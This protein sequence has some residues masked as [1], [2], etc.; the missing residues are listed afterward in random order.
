[1][2]KI[3]AALL[4]ATAL[5]RSAALAE[6]RFRVSME[7]GKQRV[8]FTL[9]GNNACVMLDDKIVCE[10]MAKEPVHVASSATN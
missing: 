6:D 3:L 7:D 5:C 10:P 1:M 2:N 4:I 9:N 8:D